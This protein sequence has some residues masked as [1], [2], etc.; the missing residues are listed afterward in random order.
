MKLVDF[1]STSKNVIGANLVARSSNLG[2]VL[3]QCSGVCVCL[4]VTDVPGEV[5]SLC[6]TS[7]HGVVH[8]LPSG[9]GC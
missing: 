4:G 5:I 6:H 8:S 9:G 3:V 7:R 1:L 2:L